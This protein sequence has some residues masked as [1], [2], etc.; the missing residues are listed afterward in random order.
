MA[1]SLKDLKP[2]IEPESYFSNWDRNL[3]S[4]IHELSGPLTAAQINLD[5][6]TLTKNKASLEFL[7]AN[8]KL[9]ED[10]LVTARRQIKRLPVEIRPFSVNKQLSLIIGNLSPLATRRG[11]RLK[12]NPM[13]D[14]TISGNPTNF[15]Q[16]ISCFIRNAIEAY[17]DCLHDHKIVT[18]EHHHGDRSLI[19][20]VRD[21]GSGINK[22][23][24]KE[25]FKPYFSTKQNSEGLGIGLS[26]AAETIKKDFGGKVEV[27]S[28]KAS[29][30]LF[31]L[32]FNN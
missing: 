32:Y 13:P 6:Y 22:E 19:I 28:D 16:V 10:Y 27:E 21:H 8:I 26:L 14:C 7:N 1:S 18:I 2:K 17:D 23:D 3:L 5:N 25:I 31:K 9:M 4:L 15:K 24:K 30:S 11:V 12:L 20:S 29:G